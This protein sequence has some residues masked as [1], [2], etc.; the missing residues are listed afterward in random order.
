MSSAVTIA[1]VS[2]PGI[3]DPPGG[4]PG[5][6]DP[7]VPSHIRTV[8]SRML[9]LR[10]G[11]VQMA[12][13]LDAARRYWLSV[14][15]EVSRELA[16][17]EQRAQAIP[18]PSLR[19]HAHE[20]M[21]K[22]GNIEGAAAFAAFAPRRHRD[23]VTRA[24]VAFQ[25]AYNY[26]DVLAEQPRIEAIPGGRR[27]HEALL[28]AL[29]SHE[30]GEPA[31]APGAPQPDYYALYP[32][33]EDGGYLDELVQTCRTALVTL[34]AY[35]AVA[36]AARRCAGRIVE[37]QSL[38]LSEKQGGHHEL[39]DWA[40]A[41]TPAG[42]ALYWWETAAAG[43]SSL[44]VYALIAAAA[45][46]CSDPGEPERIEQAYFPWIGALHSLLDHLVDHTEDMEIGQ[47]NLIDRYAS[48]E[49]AAARM[50]TLA[51]HALADAR[52]LP[53]GRQHAIVL[54]GMAGFYLSAP[55]TR[56]AR[57][58]PIA[59]GVRTALGPLMTPTLLVFKL[60]PGAM[61]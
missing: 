15:P 35:P 10:E 43:G 25:T 28:G 48:P 7:R 32:Q 14:F 21:R 55:E 37:F 30:P 46:P 16:R 2:D 19:R 53:Q 3:S 54:T 33:R 39:A 11:V 18:D 17:W 47:R 58:L 60:R 23:A 4:D 29:D 44:A 1:P 13:F 20:A 59:R 6:G 45:E 38:N 22:R 52:A 61:R 51:E 42:E 56:L 12:V 8:A 50:R 40:R 5:P 31:D 27:L 26:L 49:E 34:P 36:G 24:L 57:A 9:Q 41:E